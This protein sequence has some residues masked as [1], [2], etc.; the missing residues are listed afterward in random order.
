MKHQYQ[1]D[2]VKEFLKLQKDTVDCRSMELG[3]AEDEPLL[4]AFDVMLR[5]ARAFKQCFGQALQQNHFLGDEYLRVITGLRGLL[6]GSG[7]VSMERN[8]TT[9]SKSN[10]V[11]ESIFWKC[12]FEAGYREGD[13]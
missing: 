12:L 7:A 2:T 5:Y 11:L 4:V 3:F 9:D 8:I 13:V 6:N 1:D 10:G